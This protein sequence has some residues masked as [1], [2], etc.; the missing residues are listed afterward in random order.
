MSIGSTLHL[1]RTLRL[2]LLTAALSCFSL[3]GIA[4]AQETIRAISA[5]PKSLA[6]SESFQGFVDL[7]NEKGKG[8]VQISYAGGP[9]M[10]PP[11]QQVDAVRRGVIDMQYGPATYYLGTM[12][13]AD[14]W[15]GSTVTAAEGREKGGFE[16]M[17][18]AF[19]EKLG[20]KLLAHL[21]SGV[22]FYIYTIKE[23]KR[24]EDGGVDLDGM[25]IRSQ[26]IYNS[27]F[28]AL[29]AIPVSV[30]VPDVYTGLERSTFDGAGWPI[31]GIRDLSWDKF[32]RYRIDPGFFQAD[33]AVVINP[34]KWESLSEEA[35]AVISEAAVEYEK[36]SYDNFQ[37][38][39]EE[40]TK[41]VQE[42]GME[43][44]QIEGEA[45]EKYLDLAYDSAWDRLK[46]SGSK[47]YDALRKAY[48]TR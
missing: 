33:L 38:M 12:P 10:F 40:I 29:G 28:E 5:F 32:L 9:E 23:P 46:Q 19:A 45:A 44:I 26:P 24:T 8:V 21:D 11:N 30:P 27:F 47:Y 36:I 39:A 13:E 42:D 17:Q 34:A 15:V 14:A 37:R 7:V 48:Y 31:I 22:Q 43:I 3:A 35:K 4:N 16:I 41:Q 18:Q 1:A 25:R 20:V 6:F 2:G